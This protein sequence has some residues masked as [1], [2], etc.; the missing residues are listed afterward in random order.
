MWWPCRVLLLVFLWIAAASAPS[1]GHSGRTDRYGCHNDQISGGYHCHNNSA[2]KGQSFKSQQEM[3]EAV[4]K[5]LCPPQ[6]ESAAEQPTEIET[7][8][9][10]R[11]APTAFTCD[12]TAQRS[13]IKRVCYDA[14]RELTLLRLQDTYY[15]YCGLGAK[16]RELLTADDM[17]K[18]YHANIR[19]RFRCPPDIGNRHVK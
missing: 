12:D 19:G 7:K 18:Y 6:K 3:L 11:F 13:W 8:Y 5:G 1:S 14:N 9:C 10:G 17:G 4:E 15:C 2:C 16:V